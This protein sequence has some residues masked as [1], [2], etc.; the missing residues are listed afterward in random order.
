MQVGKL[1]ELVQTELSGGNI[2]RDSRK[3]YHPAIIKERLGVT[4]DRLIIPVFESLKLKKD[5]T[6][7]D[8][9]SI[10][11][12]DVPVSVHEG[13]Y[14]SEI[15]S[16]VDIRNILHAVISANKNRDIQFVPVSVRELS[17]LRNTYVGKINTGYVGFYQ[18]NDRFEYYGIF[19]DIK[20][21]HMNIVP[22]FSSFGLDDDVAMLTYMKEDLFNSTVMSLRGQQAVPLDLKNDSSPININS[23]SKQ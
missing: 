16:G 2:T 4:Y 18:N 10:S 3:K 17:T 1:I 22:S 14:Y 15:P 23:D 21:V 20:S 11:Y 8:K 5:F 13:I 12:P 19:P 9:L 7:I 6:Q